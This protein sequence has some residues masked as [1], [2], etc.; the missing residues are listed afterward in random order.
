MESPM[1]V[2]V[3]RCARCGHDH[4]QLTFTELANATD[5]WNRWAMC[6]NVSQP[7]MMRVT[8]DGEE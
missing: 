8:D 6:P 7:I 5:E 3:K 4:D 1:T 2:N